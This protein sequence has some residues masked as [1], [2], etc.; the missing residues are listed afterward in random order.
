MKAVT[1]DE[2][3]GL[4]YW[5]DYRDIKQATLDGTNIKTII[6]SGM[7]IPAKQHIIFQNCF[8]LM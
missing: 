5:S 7:T 2:V 1:V 6:S 3:R 8:F 4:I